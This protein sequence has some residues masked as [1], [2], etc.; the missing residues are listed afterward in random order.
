MLQPVDLSPDVGEREGFGGRDV[1]ARHD[2]FLPARFVGGQ[3]SDS[4]CY[5]FGGQPSDGR[6]V[7]SKWKCCRTSPFPQLDSFFPSLYNDSNP[8]SSSR[9]KTEKVKGDHGKFNLLS[10]ELA[11]GKPSVTASD[12]DPGVSESRFREQTF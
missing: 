11:L 12:R 10:A 9:T 3:F 6:S 2:L 7:R 1:L 8:T 4:G 5:P